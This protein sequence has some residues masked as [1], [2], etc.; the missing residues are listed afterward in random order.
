M[1]AGHDHGLGKLRHE[2][3]LRWALV[4][5]GG[6]LAA[7][8]VGAWLT[9]SLALLSDAAHMATDTLALVIAL[10]A[11]RLGRKPA[12]AQ[13]TFGY[14][15]LEAFGA[16]ANGG[17]LLVVA[18]YILWASI[19]R[20]RA[21]LPVDTGGMLVVAAAGLGVNL[22][23]MRLLRAGS[24][25]SLN[26]KG[27]YLEVWSDMLASAAVLAGA[28][29][30]RATGWTVVDPALAVGI[31]LW[32]LPRTWSLVNEAVHVL[33]EGVPKGIDLHDVRGAME[34]RPASP[35]CTTCTC[36][37]WAARAPPSPRT[38]WW[39]TTAATPS[40]CATCSRA[41]CASASTCTTSP[42]RWRPRRARA[43]TAA[44]RTGGMARPR[45]RRMTMSTAAATATRTESTGG[46]AR[47]DAS[48]HWKDP[49]PGFAA[50]MRAEAIPSRL[51][52][53]L[54]ASGSRAGA[55]PAIPRGSCSPVPLVATR[56]GRLRAPPSR[57]D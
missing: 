18:A 25:E 52:L 33:M 19:G 57:C 35:R 45:Q 50:R 12:D 43:R 16:L 51:R 44:S 3:P 1:G 17:L 37:R 7:E 8:L 26:M 54:P 4:L 13:R 34:P 29:V 14:V 6:F 28:M 56:R 36:G 20:F 10:V 47:R 31:G 42:C 49:S 11:V 2:R 15:R 46:A 39:R 53:P 9:N 40:P 55:W 24:G 32:V 22:L 23:A 41:S 48:R 27:A 21:P 5:T 38:C 30:I